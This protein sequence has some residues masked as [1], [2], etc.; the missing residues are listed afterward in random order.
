LEGRKVLF[1]AEDHRNGKSQK[2]PKCVDWL[3]EQKKKN[4]LIVVVFVTNLLNT[5][6]NAIR[7]WKE[8][9]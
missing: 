6:N 8:K 7:K 4:I 1:C 2:L 9:G 3:S 5:G